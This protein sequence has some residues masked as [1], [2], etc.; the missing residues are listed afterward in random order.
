MQR[1]ATHPAPEASV[2][3]PAARVVGPG[4]RERRY[5][6]RIADLR[7]RVEA[8]ERDLQ[9]SGRELETRSREL[10]TAAGRLQE[11]ERELEVSARVERGAARYVDRLE[12]RLDRER[13]AARQLE[14]AQKRL[15]LALGAVQRENELLR[16]RLAALAEGGAGPRRLSGRPERRGSWLARMLGRRGG[17][18]TRPGAHRPD[19]DDRAGA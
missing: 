9:A 2:L 5:L 15:A 4:R 16:E 10:A 7:E 13:E 18:R 12:Q 14:Q 3:V 8:T 11:R 17:G 1:A 19:R 6:E